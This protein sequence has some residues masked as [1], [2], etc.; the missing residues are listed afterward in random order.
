MK[1][2]TGRIIRTR[3]FKR[4]AFINHIDNINAIEEFLDKTFRYQNSSAFAKRC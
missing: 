1:R 2:A 4:H 3:L